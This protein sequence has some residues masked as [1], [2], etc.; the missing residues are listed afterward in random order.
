MGNVPSPHFS[1][2]R[3]GYSEGPAAAEYP[4]QAFTEDVSGSALLSAAR[5][6]QQQQQQKEQKEQKEQPASDASTA[7]R[8]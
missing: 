3:G 2:T 7:N 4:M 6:E 5:A 8:A 1:E